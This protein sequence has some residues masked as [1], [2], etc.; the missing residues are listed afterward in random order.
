MAVGR[1]TIYWIMWTSQS[2]PLFAH[3]NFQPSESGLLEYLV[4]ILV[5]FEN[6][7]SRVNLN[8]DIFTESVGLEMDQF[9]KGGNTC[10]LICKLICKIKITTLYII[11]INI[12]NLRR[13]YV[14][15]L[16]SAKPTGKHRYQN[17]RINKSYHYE[18]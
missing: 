16:R 8:S 7:Q 4:L 3:G 15:I 14:A 10:D 17:K 2:Q 5:I 9:F 6:E 18:N 11:K 12:T 1:T 13:K